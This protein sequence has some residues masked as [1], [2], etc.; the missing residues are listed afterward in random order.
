[1]YIAQEGKLTT[2]E[3]KLLPNNTFPCLQE[4]E[5]CDESKK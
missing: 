1:M 2:F 3:T 4:K 5:N